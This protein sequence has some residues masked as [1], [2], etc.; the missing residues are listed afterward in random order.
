MSVEKLI[1]VLLKVLFSIIAMY[2]SYMLITLGDNNFTFYGMT[3][4]VLLRLV[5]CFIFT[6]LFI[7][8][9]WEI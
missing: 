3:G 9:I 8:K 5:L 7:I 2:V 6:G 1:I 4:W